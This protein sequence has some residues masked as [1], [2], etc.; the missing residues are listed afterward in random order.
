MQTGYEE[1]TVKRRT[2]YNR[3][4]SKEGS[5][6]TAEVCKKHGNSTASF[7]EYKS[8]FGGM[9]ISDTRKLKVLEDENDKLKNLLAEQ[10]FD[11]SGSLGRS[12]SF[13]TKRMLVFARCIAN[14]K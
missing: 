8:K 9:D 1:I 14:S 11:N 3:S 5:V 4:R 12:L 13:A 7:C 6:P 10:M 2:N